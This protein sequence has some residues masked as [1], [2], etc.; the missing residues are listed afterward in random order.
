MRAPFVEAL[1]NVSSYSSFDHSAASPQPNETL[2]NP[3]PPP[4]A[5]GGE[6][7]SRVSIPLLSKEGAGEIMRVGATLVALQGEA[8]ASLTQVYA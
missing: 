2:E 3:S 4:F 8:K 6:T 1:L 7:F 5:K